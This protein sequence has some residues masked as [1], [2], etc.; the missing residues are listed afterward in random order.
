MVHK[1]DDPEG[2]MFSME[3]FCGGYGLYGFNCTSDL[4]KGHWS[5]SY[6]G[7]IEIHG[8]LSAQPTD[9]I[10]IIIMAETPA[11]YSLDNTRSV[12]KDW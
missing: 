2:L 9:N 6:R 3:D 10:S 5:P 8:K 1:S 11:V 4:D 7:S 12:T